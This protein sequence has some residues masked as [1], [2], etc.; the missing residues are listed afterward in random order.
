M[1]IEFINSY[2][3][4]HCQ[5]PTEWTVCNLIPGRGKVFISFP[6]HPCRLWG[7]SSP[8]FRRYWGFFQGQELVELCHCFHLYAFLV[9]TETTLIFI[10]LIKL[11]TVPNLARQAESS[12]VFWSSSC[13]QFPRSAASVCCVGC[14]EWW[15]NASS[16]EASTPSLCK[17]MWQLVYRRGWISW[18][19]H[20]GAYI[21]TVDCDMHK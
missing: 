5:S 1:S 10:P 9:W 11:N 8:L 3:I 17:Q 20:D 12:I 4:H 13:L 18:Q 19:W 2:V 21:L 15:R 14:Y 7:S 16:V 6:K